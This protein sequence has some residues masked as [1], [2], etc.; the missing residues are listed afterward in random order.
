MRNKKF[1]LGML[2]VILASGLL[3]T[4]C[5]TSSVKVQNLDLSEAHVKGQNIPK[6]QNAT[7]GVDPELIQKVDEVMLDFIN[8]NGRVMGYYTVDL[9][10]RYTSDIEHPASLV[11][12]SLS[13]GC[14]FVPNMLGMPFWINS[15]ETSVSLNI[16]DSRGDIVETFIKRGRFDLAKGI[17]YGH[18]PTLKAGK[19]YSEGLKAG[20]EYM[21]KKSASINAMLYAAGPVTP[22]NSAYARSKIAGKN[23]G[24]ASKQTG[25]GEKAAETPAVKLG[26]LIGVIG[27]FEGGD[28]VVN[29]KDDTI[30]RL[31]PMGRNLIVDAGGQYIYLQSTFPMQTVVKCRVTSGDRSLIKKGMKVYLKP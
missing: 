21:N 6:L 7:P 29:G 15:F 25:G 10:C 9:K 3:I 22:H 8:P 23:Y 2:I 13:G 16:F 4:S 12:A 17:Y 11:F 1:S 30:A 19:N 18:D 27:G 31:A 28:I 14:L 20:L 26:Q 24:A 5:T